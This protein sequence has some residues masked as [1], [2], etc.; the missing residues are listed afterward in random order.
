MRSMVEGAEGWMERKWR[1]P[2]TTRSASG[3]P[4]RA[5][6][7]SRRH[8]VAQTLAEQGERDQ[9]RHQHSPR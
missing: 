5:G 6:E 1:A 8:P 9:D 4:P 2:S 7:D 3:P